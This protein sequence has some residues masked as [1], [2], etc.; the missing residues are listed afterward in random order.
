[1]WFLFSAKHP[2]Q[3]FFWLFFV[4]ISQRPAVS[5]EALAQDPPTDGFNRRNNPAKN[6]LFID[7]KIDIRVPF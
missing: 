7:E 1:L 3:E 5:F 4:D 6:N 2:F